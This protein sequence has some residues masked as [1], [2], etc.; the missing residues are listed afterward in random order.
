MLIEV[1]KTWHGAP[2]EAIS[3]WFAVITTGAL[4]VLKS[5]TQ[6]KLSSIPNTQKPS[7]NV[8]E[9]RRLRL[10][11]GKGQTAKHPLLIRELAHL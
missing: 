10:S 3:T 2:V 6:F 8:M 9:P 1:V 11:D 7:S 4:P 5:G